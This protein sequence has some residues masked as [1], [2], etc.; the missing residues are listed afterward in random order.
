VKKPFTHAAVTVFSIV[1]LVQLLRLL[2]GWEVTIQGFAVPIWASGVAV[3]VAGG[4]AVTVCR[5][6]LQ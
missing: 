2:M 1:A 6:R 4:L 5:E 3:V